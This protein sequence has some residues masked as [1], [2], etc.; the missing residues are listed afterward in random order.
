[1]V[2]QDKLWLLNSLAVL[3]TR[4]SLKLLLCYVS[5][6]PGSNTK[7]DCYR[8]CKHTLRDSCQVHEVAARLDTVPPLLQHLNSHML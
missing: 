8:V 3:Q 2:N 7:K 1:M 5:N 4:L 6:A